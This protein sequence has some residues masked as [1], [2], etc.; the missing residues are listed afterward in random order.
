MD[1][2]E[3]ISD[4]L[5]QNGNSVHPKGKLDLASEHG[6]DWLTCRQC[7][8]Q[9][10]VNEYNRGYDF[11]MVTEGDGDCEENSED[12]EYSARLA[13]A[14]SSSNPLQRAQAA[15]SL[16][17]G[18]RKQAT[19]GKGGKV[20]KADKE[21]LNKVIAAAQ[22]ASVYSQRY[23][24][25]NSMLM[26]SYDEL[27][28]GDAEGAAENISNATQEV[29]ELMDSADL[30]DYLVEIKDAVGYEDEE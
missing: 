23:G 24:N 26:S 29:N 16:A 7:G 1:K 15:L 8:A 12:M 5:S 30:V 21:V 25:V 27:K 3:V 18:L 4:F 9:W 11:D 14:A 10:S 22:L 19:G 28:S 13:L 17:E 20:R 2:R 6:R